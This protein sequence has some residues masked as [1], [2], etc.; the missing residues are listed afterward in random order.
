VLF[1]LATDPPGFAIDEAAEKLG[2]SLKL[3]P[4]LEPHRKEIEN[5]LPRIHVKK[6]QEVHQNG[7]SAS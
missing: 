2:E 7:R 3:P 4:W 5:S 1:E 6:L